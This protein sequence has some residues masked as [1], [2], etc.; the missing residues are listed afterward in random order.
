MPTS[1][2]H[3]PPLRTAL[4]ALLLITAVPGRAEIDIHIDIRPELVPVPG[5]PVY[6]AAN[7]AVNYFFYDGAYWLYYD[8]RW[9]V[10]EW[11]DGPWRFVDPFDVPDFLLRVPVRYYRRPPVYFHTWH[12][13][14][15]PRWGHHWGPAWERR[16]PHWNRWDH[17]H[18]PPRA[19]LPHFHQQRQHHHRLHEQQQRQRLHE[20]QRQHQHQQQRQRQHE[21]RR[22]H[23]EQQGRQQHPHWQQ[24]Q[25]REQQRPSGHRRDAD[26]PRQR[27]QGERRGEQ[28]KPHHRPSQERRQWQ[29]Q[30]RP[31]GDAPGPS[32]GRDQRGG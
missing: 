28:V 23:R 22:E 13:H 24:Q 10:S 32:R 11:Y 19:P 27:Y 14:A 21:Q 3:W 29:G 25:R 15:P 12:Y 5:Y 16:R 30:Q 2:Y 1:R 8:D 6:Y 18:V 31:R 26:Q 4:L 20:Q 9:Y 7:L 17:R